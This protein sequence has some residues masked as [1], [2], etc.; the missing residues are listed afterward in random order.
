MEMKK[1][2]ILFILAMLAAVLTACGTKQAADD[3]PRPWAAPSTK[4]AAAE[5]Q[6]EWTKSE[7]LPTLAALEADEI[8]ITLP[9]GVTAA[10]IRQLEHALWM[11]FFYTPLNPDP[12]AT[13]QDVLPYLTNGTVPWGILY[14]YDT[15][16]PA[17]VHGGYEKL[18]VADAPDPR[19]LFPDAYYKV[20][21]TV[22]QFLFGDVFGVRPDW[23]FSTD[24]WYFEDG[25][26]YFTCLP[27]G[28]EA[29]E[30]H[31]RACQTIGENRYRITAELQIAE[32][33]DEFSH[34]ASA[35]VEVSLA[36]KDGLRYWTIARVEP[37]E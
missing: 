36:E 15:F 9:Q 1:I 27:T 32:G 18:S 13:A 33:E 23:T 30:T 34:A 35:F 19:G 12:V 37:F 17:H 26:G 22:L 11:Q 21:Q 2:C 10:D 5:T 25:F 16:D 28:L 4:E 8:G 24:A 20:D 7:E 29:Y 6:T 14:M 3:G 31:V